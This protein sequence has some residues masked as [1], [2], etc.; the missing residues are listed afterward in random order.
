[1]IRL[2]RVALT[3]VVL[4][5][6]TTLGACSREPEF[7]LVIRGGS[8]MDGAGG[9]AQQADVGIKGDRIV[10]IGNLSGRSTSQAIDAKGRIVTP[11]FI[12]VKSRLTPVS[13]LADSHLR[14]GITTEIVV[15][16]KDAFGALDARGTVTN[17]GALVPLSSP[18]IDAAMRDGAFGVADD[19]TGTANQEALNAAASVVS[20]YDG[21][22]MLPVESAGRC[23]R[24]RT[25]GAGRAGTTHRDRG[26]LTASA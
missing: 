24:C 19:G 15:T 12:D 20:R 10:A 18:S 21:T 7:A 8:V 13:G 17:V 3:W 1:M 5:A 4:G 9:E 6:V 23:D 11:G 14:Q 22:L 25:S 16:D 2:R 26:T